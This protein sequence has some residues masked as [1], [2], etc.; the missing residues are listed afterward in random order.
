MLLRVLVVDDD[1][2]AREL[3]V[4]V[5]RA[6]GHQVLELPSPIGVSRVAREQRVDVVVLDIVL[7]GMKGDRLAQLLRGN[8]VFE[9][10][11]VVLVSGDSALDLEQLAV[12]VEAD[13]V[14]NKSSA[15]TGLC[16]AVELAARRR[17]RKVPD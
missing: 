16:R 8:S 10:L 12:R 5:L 13:A 2:V 17:S 7:P 3:L 11:G 9:H 6:A 4:S 14:V 15:K 1:D